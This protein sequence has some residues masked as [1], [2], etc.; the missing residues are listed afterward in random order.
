M[1]IQTWSIFMPYILLYFQL[2]FAPLI[3]VK[4]VVPVTLL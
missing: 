1:N 4:M 2:S 3:P